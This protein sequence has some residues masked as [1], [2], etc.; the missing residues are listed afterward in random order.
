MAKT[1]S[2]LTC[3]EILEPIAEDRLLLTQL[4]TLGFNTEFVPWQRLNGSAHST[5]A[6]LIRTTWDYTRHLNEFLRTLRNLSQTNRPLFNRL[7]LIE[8]NSTKTYLRDLEMQGV[9]IPLTFWYDQI[10]D[11]QAAMLWPSGGPSKSWVLKPQVSASARGT[12]LLESPATYPAQAAAYQQGGWGP[13]MI[14]EFLPSI[15]QEGEWSLVFFDQEFSHAVQKIPK[16]GDFRVQ[17]KYGG[18]T[19]PCRPS[20]DAIKVGRRILDL[21][22]ESPLYARV[23]LIR[24]PETEQWALIELELI[25]PQLFLE[26]DPS[27]AARLAQALARRL[28]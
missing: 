27:S 11:V 25:E 19:K 24:H 17:K 7:P 18:F 4:Q 8:W 22:P 12:Y 1:V 20:A 14:Q 10:Q 21:L 2:L 9:A 28:V 3:N 5:G 13:L 26:F 16:R 23:D 15:T 6:V